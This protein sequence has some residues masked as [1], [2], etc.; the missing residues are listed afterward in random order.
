MKQLNDVAVRIFHFRSNDLQLFL[1]GDLT[2]QQTFGATDHDLSVTRGKG[3]LIDVPSFAYL[4]G[5]GHVCLVANELDDVDVAINLANQE[6][7]RRNV[8]ER[9]DVWLLRFDG[10]NS[11][12]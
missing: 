2:K 10:A 3:E 8:N 12:V 11:L 1:L 9:E 5:V 4:K 7:F 6:P